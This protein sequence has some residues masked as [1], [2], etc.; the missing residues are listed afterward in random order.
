MRVWYIDCALAFHA[1]EASLILAARSKVCRYSLVGK[2]TG[3]QSV[4][5][6]SNP[7]A[8]SNVLLWDLNNPQSP[9]ANWVIGHMGMSN[10]LLGGPADNPSNV[11]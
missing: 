2:T 5:A 9:Y 1:N 8:R 4:V 7:A 10:R 3:C 6:G 11:R